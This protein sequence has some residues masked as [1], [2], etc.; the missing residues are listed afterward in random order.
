[1]S[2]GRLA[3]QKGRQFA[4]S[5]LLASPRD[6]LVFLFPSR[7]TSR[8][9]AS[10]AS[11]ALG[12]ETTPGFTDDSQEEYTTRVETSSP[13][14]RSPPK[15]Q[16]QRNVVSVWPHPQAAHDSANALLDQKSWSDWRSRYISRKS[17]TVQKAVSRRVRDLQKSFQV[18]P[19][20]GLQA[21]HL[22]QRS[23]RHKG[24]IVAKDALLKE[25]GSW[26][27]D[28]R[29]AL[30]ELVKLQ[31]V[32][33]VN[34]TQRNVEIRHVCGKP[35]NNY[36]VLPGQVLL[37]AVWSRFT[38]ANHVKDL[39]K[40]QMT[41]L[42]DRHL[43]GSETQ[44]QLAVQDALMALF[45]DE[46]LRPH[47]TSSSIKTALRF[48]YRHNLISSAR[49]LCNLVEE[50]E[51]P[52]DIDMFNL[53]L[54]GA[55]GRK[56]LHSFTYILLLMKR[57][58]VAPDPRT[59]TALLQVLR[60]K[61]AQLYVLEAGLRFGIFDDPGDARDAV[62]HII[63]VE[64]LEHIHTKEELSVFTN[65]LDRLYGREWMSVSTGN[66]M[67][68]ILG[69]AGLLPQAVDALRFITQRGW[70]PNNVT[71]QTFL[72]HCR[73]LREPVPA[74]AILR[75]F[76]FAYS[77]LPGQAE[78]D[79]LF[80]LAWKARYM[81]LCRVVW[82][83]AC[84][85]AAVSYRM[86]NLVLRS[87]FRNTPEHPQSLTQHWTKIA[88][89]V[90]VGIDSDS[91]ITTGKPAEDPDSAH[92]ILND[93]LTWSTPGPERERSKQLVSSLLDRDMQAMLHF[94]LRHNFLDLFAKAL[95][96]DQEWKSGDV[97]RKRS[98]EWMLQ[99]AI[100]VEVNP[101]IPVRRVGRLS[102]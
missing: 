95:E 81:N 79:A 41:R 87:L 74:L 59:W 58:G 57:K 56:D 80:M 24:H 90:I 15:L 32:C 70:R 63:E 89:K 69:E 65:R 1:M 86:Q 44:H 47:I 18:E 49:F 9:L 42:V 21:Q 66:K 96:M 14:T 64:L 39:V 97:L 12:T 5:T 25:K 48:F 13:P 91:L 40:C 73:R 7:L 94:Q 37:P 53:M 19:A 10:A 76:E 38:F 54:R 61:S 26:S 60:S 46:A 23:Q 99:H 28:W 102:S 8:S 17:R 55:A 52:W 43:Y 50:L 84:L 67:C 4:I 45:R 92:S 34:A 22:S 88:G 72:S 20:K 100:T 51:I 27:Y 33:A 31:E 101:R 83:V 30:A 71:L 35:T 75:L 2:L 78:Y 93:S 82:R 77:I 85:K 3:G 62:R 98:G 68:H 36:Q 11:P 6:A 16:Q 29:V